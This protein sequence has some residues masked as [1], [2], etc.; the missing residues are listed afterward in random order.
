MIKTLG[1]LIVFCGVTLLL[2]CGQGLRAESDVVKEKLAVQ[3]LENG[4]MLYVYDIEIN[5][6]EYAHFEEHMAY[7]GMLMDMLAPDF[8]K[9][10]LKSHVQ[11]FDAIQH[12]GEWKAAWG[13]SAFPLLRQGCS[14]QAS[15]PDI[16]SDL[17]VYDFFETL[18]LGLWGLTGSQFHVLASRNA[19][20]L[21]LTRI[22]SLEEPITSKR[23]SKTFVAS[24]SEDAFCVDNLYKWRTMLP[25]LANYGLLSIINDER[26]WSKSAYKGVRSRMSYKNPVLTLD[27][28]FQIVL[29]RDIVTSKLWDIYPRHE[30]PK[31]L[32]GVSSSI[33]ELL[34]PAP[35]RN[36]LGGQ[37]RIG[38]N[39]FQGEF[40]GLSKA[41]EHLHTA[42]RD[43]FKSPPI[44]MLTFDV[45][46]LES[47]THNV[48]KRVQ[49]SL[50]VVIK[51]S[52]DVEKHVK[53][54]Q[55]LPY[56][57]LPQL[58]SMT[59]D[60]IQHDDNNKI[61]RLL[62]CSGSDCLQRTAYRERH[63]KHY[64]VLN[65]RTLTLRKNARHEDSAASDLGKSEPTHGDFLAL[66]DIELEE[67]LSVPLV[68]YDK[69]EY[70]IQFGFSVLMPP[71]SEL[72]CRV[73]IQKNKLDFD[74]IDYSMHRGQLI[75]SGILIESDN[76]VFDDFCELDA[77]VHQ[78]GEF[79]SYIILADNTMPFNV[80]AGTGVVCGLLFGL[81]FNLATRKGYAAEE[82]V[83][84]HSKTE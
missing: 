49:S 32:P 54:I 44:P 71:R 34:V 20:I 55:P 46:E 41:F 2:L 21:D 8:A 57:A 35:F 75:H 16:Y 53:F 66:Y 9:L 60:I 5:T 74:D 58:S 25:S 82:A 52:H 84:R 24:Y 33:V 37:D 26:I 45:S 80:M 27:V 40:S 47:T 69:S 23:K 28:Q 15:W 30:M 3:P 18:A 39:V 68:V 81:V 78:T 42:T 48:L 77:T 65:T 12:S 10:F 72:A 61:K 36:S 11:R 64:D 7:P 51:N 38:F 31:M 62:S 22:A 73:D 17:E 43:G 63:L 79:F 83:K 76:A 67:D 4:D 6:T 14:L 70:W 29:S 59:I 56:W 19:V 1:D 50:S 13:I